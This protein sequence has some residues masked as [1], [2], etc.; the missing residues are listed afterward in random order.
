MWLK[1]IALAHYRKFSIF[2]T[3][4]NPGVDEYGLLVFIFLILDS[5]LVLQMQ[6]RKFLL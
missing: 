1:V 3:L 5:I 4:F 2:N 6:V